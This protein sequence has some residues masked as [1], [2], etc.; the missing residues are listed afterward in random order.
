[1]SVDFK[2]IKK[3]SKTS[4]NFDEKLEY[5]NKELK[6]TGLREGMVTGKMYQGS[7]Q[8]PNQDYNDFLGLSQGGYALGLS[9][10]DGNSLGNATI[11]INPSTGQSGVALSPPHPV[12]GVK[13]VASTVT[14]AV[15]SNRAL[16]PG[17]G[18]RVHGTNDDGSPRVINDGSAV[19]F[20]DSAYNGGEGRWLNFEFLDGELGFW[21]TNF[22]G[23]FF[24]NTNLD[25]Y[26]LSGVNVGTQIKNKIAPINFGANGEIGAPS[27]T[28]LTQ[29]K[30]GDPGFLPINIDGLSTQAFNYLKGKADSDIAG[31]YDL[32]KRGQVPFLTPDQV[33][34]ILVDPKYQKLLQDDPDILPILQRMRAM[35]DDGT[36]IASTDPS[37]A[38]PSAP[39]VPPDPSDAPSVSVDSTKDAKPNVKDAKLGM[40][41][42][43]QDFIQTYPGSTVVDYLQSLPYRATDFMTPNPDFPGAWDLNTKGYEN[44]FLNGDLSALGNKDGIPEP[45]NA[46]STVVPSR[47]VA[48]ASA[49]KPTGFLDSILSAGADAVGR[50]AAK[51]VFDY[52]MDKVEKGHNGGEHN[53]NNLLGRSKNAIERWYARN[54]TNIVTAREGGKSIFHDA[55][56]QDFM[57]L[58]QKDGNLKNIT[59][60]LDLARGDGIFDKGDTLE[61]IKHYDFNGERDLAGG[62]VIGNLGSKGYA[63]RKGIMK[64]LG[65]DGTK[66]S[67]LMKLVITIDQKTGAVKTSVKESLDESVR[68]GHFEPE[69]L[70]VDIEDLRKGI[71][72]EFPKDPPPK[73]IGGYSE[74]SRL[75]PVKTPSN[76]SAGDIGKKPFIKITKKDIA[77]NHLLSDSDI[78]EFMDT[79]NKINEYIKNHPEELIYAQ[80]RYPFHDPRLAQLNWQMDQML[81]ASKEYMDKHFPENEKLFNRIKKKI[82]NTIDQTD[83][84]NFKGTK[85]PKFD[86]TSLEDFKRKKEVYSRFMK[87]PVKTKKLFQKRG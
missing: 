24:H 47:T 75:A 66:T 58:S 9:G 84:K 78:K 69:S 46:N 50:G 72:P 41:M 59:G 77:R 35:A 29:T 26:Q 30:L 3:Y 34:K 52:Y 86:N 7:T 11:G 82:K 40:W 17:I 61:I 21:D 54:K 43:R 60:N 71:M 33:N 42:S 27:T 31:V 87:K 56:E 62:G 70:T 1:M 53:I 39:P 45:R 76:S 12:T 74:K 20:F 22:L 10:A 57:H 68:L 85:L 2:R 4:N 81:D 51:D 23:F 64:Y 32:M 83:P 15:G 13:R 28:V 67:P 14:N 80:E 79:I 19:W 6:K 18:T 5:L 65:D 8:V 16:R 48:P 73:L 37:A 63:K 25:Q 49:A 36:E 44:Y 38:F 55:A